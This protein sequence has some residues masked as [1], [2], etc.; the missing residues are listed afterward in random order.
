MKPIIK[1]QSKPRTA[2]APWLAARLTGNCRLPLHVRLPEALLG[3]LQ[4]LARREHLTLSW[5]I[6][7]IIARYFGLDRPT[8]V[9][10]SGKRGNHAK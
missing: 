5:T 8:Y 2:Y 3:H 7:Q 10:K 4:T 9:P 6:E 1:R